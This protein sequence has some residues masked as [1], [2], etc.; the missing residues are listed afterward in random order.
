VVPVDL[1]C[2]S[3]T[4]ELPADLYPILMSASR[5]ANPETVVIFGGQG[6]DADAVTRCGGLVVSDLADLAEVV[7]RL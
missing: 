3:V 5:D 7:E 4:P 2:F 1:V 6:V